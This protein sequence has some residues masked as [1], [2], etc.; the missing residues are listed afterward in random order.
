MNFG[1]DGCERP[2]MINEVIAAVGVVLVVVLE[3]WVLLRNLL[4]V[5]AMNV[6]RCNYWTSGTCAYVASN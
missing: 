3:L 2:G 4:F 6:S 1:D 5:G